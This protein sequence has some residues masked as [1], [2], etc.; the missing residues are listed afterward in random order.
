[1]AAEKFW[2][3]EDAY[4]MLRGQFDTGRI[5]QQQFEEKLRA[6]MVQDARGRY[7]MLG[8]DS[9]KWYFYDGQNWVQGDPLAGAAPLSATPRRTPAN[10]AT[11]SQLGIEPADSPPATAASAP[12]ERSFPVLPFLL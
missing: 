4:F 9:G 7:W 1:M 11:A 12:G 5:S 6:Q 3:A 8:A 10:P 2:A